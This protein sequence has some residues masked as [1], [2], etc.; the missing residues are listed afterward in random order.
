MINWDGTM[1][2]MI[3]FEYHSNLA[4]IEIGLRM[5]LVFMERH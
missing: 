1:M 2:M 5:L 3:L 4:L